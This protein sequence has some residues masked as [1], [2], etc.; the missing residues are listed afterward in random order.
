MKKRIALLICLAMLAVP[1]S[2]CYYL[3]E[4]PYGQ[5]VP[6]GEETLSQE[7]LVQQIDPQLDELGGT[8]IDYNAAFAVY[9]P[10]TVMIRAGDHEITW[11]V[12]FFFLHGTI[13]NLISSLGSIESWTEHL[14]ADYSAEDMVLSD[15]LD[16]ILLYAALET[17]AASAGVT[18]NDDFNAV[19]D[20]EFAST[21]ETYGGEEAFLEL[22]WEEDGIHSREVYNYLV[23]ISELA[24]QYF[25][26]EFGEHGEKL[27]DDDI[28]EFT[29]GDGYLM[30][31]HIL[32]LKADHTEHD[33][34][35]AAD[36]CTECKELNAAALK[37]TEEISA[38]LNKL[39]DDGGNPD[40]YFD[41]YVAEYSEDTG[42]ETYPNGY[43]FQSGDMVEEFYN[44]CL[45]LDIG[46]YGD[47]IETTYGYHIVYRLPINY[48]E[49]P[50]SASYGGDTRT[51]R[52]IV[53]YTMLDST[54]NSFRETITANY[55]DEYNFMDFPSIFILGY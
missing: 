35:V 46:T 45:N 8:T 1:M 36:V 19:V 47:I 27:S 32:R 53:A 40:E 6:T 16:V 25:R 24:N 34:S 26:Y 13:Q 22:L 51:L 2:G 5:S 28:A 31:K 33:G 29:A 43:L 37:Q 18:V 50:I 48:D 10:D 21:A 12:L 17:C 41:G 55:T 39:S 30:A 7:D 52:E 44:E 54:L 14:Y 4:S 15:A 42:S 23:Y 11:E 3:D 49:N 20:A 38:E 9:A